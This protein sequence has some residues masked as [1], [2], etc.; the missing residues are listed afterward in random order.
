MCWDG[1]IDGHFLGSLPT[2]AQLSKPKLPHGRPPSLLGPLR[3]SPENVDHGFPL[4]LA[5]STSKS[6]QLSK[7]VSHGNLPLS[8]QKTES[9]IHS[10]YISGFLALVSSNRL[11]QERGSPW[12]ENSGVCELGISLHFHGSSTQNEM[13]VFFHDKRR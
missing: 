8:P 13:R 6:C 10:F 9:L 7:L 4:L 12:V 5:Q 11:L 1:G 2:Q 3:N